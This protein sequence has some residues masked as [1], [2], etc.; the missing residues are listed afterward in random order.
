[1]WRN[2]TLPRQAGQATVEHIG[3][4]VV[5]ALLMASLSLW[6]AQNIRPSP[7][8][9][10]I[11]ASIVDHLQQ[12]A[13]GSPGYRFPAVGAPFTAVRGTDDEPIGRFL[14]GTV[15]LARDVVVI[16]GPALAKGFVERVK[17]RAVDMVRDPIGTA[18]DTITGL[19]QGNPNILAVIR[20]RVGDIGDYVEALRGMSREEMIRTVAEDLGAAGAEFV[21]DRG[22]GYILREGISKARGRLSR[23]ADSP[24]TSTAP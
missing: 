24:P 3:V 7:A 14:K 9:P 4:V 1:M 19:A 20:D 10:P 16:G 22:R 17:E 2:R 5:V 6:A 21:I 11:V 12:E 8:P 13:P 18:E 15:R 23:P